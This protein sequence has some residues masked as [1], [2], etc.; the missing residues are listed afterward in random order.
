MPFEFRP[1]QKT[2]LNSRPILDIMKWIKDPDAN[3]RPEIMAPLVVSATGTGK[4]AMF[5]AVASKLREWNKRTVVLTHRREILEQTLKSMYR[6]GTT[7]GQIVAGRPM[8]GDLIQVASVP[9]LVNRLGQVW[10]PDLIITDEAHHS[11]AGNSWG[12]VHGFWGSVPRIGFSATPQRLDGV[13][14]RA[15]FDHIV[16]GLSAREATEDGYLTFPM[17]YKDPRELYGTLHIDKGDYDTKEQEAVFVENQ[18]KGREIMGD[19]IK[20]YAKHLGGAPTLV[21]CVSVKHADLMADQFRQAGYRAVMVWGDMPTDERDA[22]IYGLADGSVQIVTFCD[23]IGEG[24]DIPVAT[25]LVLLRKTLSLSLYLQWCGR[26]GRPVYAEGRDLSTREGRLEAI[27]MGGKP[28]SIIL[29]HAGNFALHGHPL[30]DRAWSLDSQKRPRGEAP[31]AT[32]TCPKCYGVWPGRPH[33]CPACGYDFG[34]AVASAQREELRVV[35]GE[36]VEAGL[37]PN[38]AASWAAFIQRAVSA[39][40]ELKNKMIMAKAFEVIGSHE[41]EE[42]RKRKVELLAEAVGYKVGWAHRMWELKKRRSS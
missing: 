13:G 22:A 27:A 16:L 10:R 9:T 34:A 40:V 25:G 11:V 12:K 33:R 39:P 23:L 7:S 35:E 37:D 19:V 8:T 14:L 32:T 18:A 15:S 5:C 2:I 30:A 21:A 4:T 31:P 3:P 28:R 1:Y 29:D 41:D 26:V 36:L 17:V 20:H 6:M 42:T 38:D 24:V